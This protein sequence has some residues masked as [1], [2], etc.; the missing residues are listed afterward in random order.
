MGSI[1]MGQSK[2]RNKSFIDPTQLQYLSQMWNQGGNFFGS[3]GAN[4][5]AGAAQGFVDRLSSN[6]F[7]QQLGQFATPNNAMVQ[8]QMD[9]LGQNLGRQFSQQILP[10]IQSNAIAAGQLGGGRQGVAQGIASQG[11]AD[12]FGQG[13][14]GIMSNAYNQAQQATGLGANLYGQQAMMG[15]QGLG[16]MQQMAAN[17]YLWWSQMLGGPTVLNKGSS[18]AWN[19]GMSVGG[20][21]GQK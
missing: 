17:P 16:Q 13:A 15:L 11:F 14:S 10:G 2:S 3:G 7:M 1:N 9:M 4:F 12:A 20:G 6:P 8:N 5:D 21:G 18:D 19:F